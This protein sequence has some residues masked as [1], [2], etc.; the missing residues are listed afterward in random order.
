MK[1]IENIDKEKYEGF[2]KKHKKSHF[3]QSYAWGEFSKKEKNLIPH[4]VGLIDDKDNLVATALLLEKKLPLNLCYFYIPRGFILDYSNEEVVKEFTKDLKT[5]SKKKKAIFFK[6]D[7]DI[8]YNQE[9]NLGNKIVS[10]NKKELELLKKLGYKHLGFTKN[11][12]TMQPR[13]TFR[14]NMDKPWEEI[15]NNFSKTTK[16]RIKKAEDLFVEVNIGNQND[17]NT[18]YNLMI[19]TENRKDFITHNE[20]YYKSLYEIWNKDN[21]C[22]LF[23][24]TINLD[25]IINKQTNTLDELKEELNLLPKENLSKSQNTKKQELEKR[26]D[27]I[28]S[29]LSRYM[30]IRTEYD[31]KITLSGHFIIEYGDKAWVLY[32]GNHNILTD[33]YTN[34][35]TYKEHIKYY[36]DKGIKI[37]DQF[38]T[39]GDLRSDNPLIGL[40][41]FK[42]KFGGDYVEFTGEFD[43]IINK[44]M[45]FI[46][47]KLVPIYR[48]LVKNIAKKKRGQR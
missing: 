14:I 16:Q 6:I 39:I 36:Y 27:K 29:D 25:K 30:S 15:E 17:I 42:K 8:I 46:F 18:F 24:G 12:E 32:A 48:N 23:L 5:Y 1:F 3:L 20:Q 43:Y 10:E 22:N 40:H 2:V 47:T 33:T 31:N 44:P 37:Y 21:S 7:P 4:Y 19:L 9:D 26:I 34:Y 41:E 11:F 13:Y 45:Y 38:G 35:E 28:N